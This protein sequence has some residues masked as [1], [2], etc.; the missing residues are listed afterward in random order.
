MPFK[1]ILRGFEL[2]PDV[3]SENA[4]LMKIDEN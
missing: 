3:W 1:V 2:F 4:A